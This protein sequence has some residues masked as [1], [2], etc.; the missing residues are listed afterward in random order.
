M[1][2]KRIALI[3]VLVVFCFSCKKQ[4][5]VPNTENALP[6]LWKRLGD[7]PGLGRV[8]AFGFSINGKGYIIGGNAAGG[9]DSH[10]LNDL[11]EYDPGA[12]SWIRKADYPGQSGE[13]IRGFVI[14]GKAYVGTGYGQR[15][16]LPG[17]S[18]PQNDDFWEYDP[19]ADKWTQKASFAGGKRENVIAFTLNG[20]GYLGLGTDNAYASN[21]K[22]IWRYNVVADTWTRVADYPG[23]GSFGAIGFAIGDKAYVGLGG[24]SP[25]IAAK[26]LWQY[27]PS[28]DKWI[29]LADFPGSARAFSGQFVIGNTAYI[30]MG[31][32]PKETATDWYRYN[33]DSNTWLK[34]TYLDGPA[35]YDMIA[36][37]INNI[38]YIGTGNPGQLNDIWKF[39]PT[40][41]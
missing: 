26:D 1:L 11:W 41:K 10:L 6:G 25:D 8:R 22:D 7:F 31:S 3:V 30:G 9:F 33:A 13:Y 24:A 20:A 35:R 23:Q 38:G 40:K 21:Y 37:T 27:D 36:F 34:S 19:L 15:L 39:T 18:L 32:T 2:L 28:T 14:N 16:A 29:K 12:D 4:A 17:S 5:F